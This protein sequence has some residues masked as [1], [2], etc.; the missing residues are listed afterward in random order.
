MFFVDES[1]LRLNLFQGKLTGHVSNQCLLRRKRKIHELKLPRAPQ[2][3][4][5]F[6][7]AT[8]QRAQLNVSEPHPVAMV[9]Q[10]DAPLLMQPKPVYA[11]VFTPCY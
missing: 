4:R 2:P 8:L 3:R 11:F 7:L 6:G 10:E 5:A 9:L 1:G